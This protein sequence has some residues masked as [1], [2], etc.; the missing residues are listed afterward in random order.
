[1]G[2]TFVLVVGV[3]ED[4]VRQPRL[5]QIVHGVVAVGV[6]GHPRSAFIY[7]FIRIA[8]G[9]LLHV[10]LIFQDALT[11]DVGVLD[12]RLAHL[13]RSHHLQVTVVGVLVVGEVD[14]LLQDV[15]VRGA[16]IVE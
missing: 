4:A 12:W 14:L 3:I 9:V 6:I 2:L 1:M 13:L 10:V 7:T 8:L 11:P 5:G 16:V 15:F